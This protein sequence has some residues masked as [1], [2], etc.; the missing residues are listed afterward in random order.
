[1]DVN[2]AKSLKIMNLIDER[3]KF[4]LHNNMCI[5][6]TVA[7]YDKVFLDLIVKHELFK[8][9][10]STIIGIEKVFIDR[11]SF[12]DK[13]KVVCKIADYYKVKRF[14]KVDNFL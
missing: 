14:K 4:I 3:N 13:F 5:I 12:M 7:F 11:L 6:E 10:I 2:T 1:M 9:K 8:E